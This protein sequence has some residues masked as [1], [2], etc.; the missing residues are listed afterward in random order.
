MTLPT[1]PQSIVDGAGA[2]RFGTYTGELSRIELANLTGRWAVPRAL[3]RLKRK[4]WQYT[5]VSTPEIAAFF[6]VVDLGYTANAFLTAVELGTGRVL[7]DESFLNVPGPHVEVSDTPGAGLSARFW[8]PGASFAASRAEGDE[9]YKVKVELSRVVR[10]LAGPVKWTGELLAAGGPPALTVIAP[11]AGD[12]K[13]NVTQ[14]WSALL[15]FGSLEVDGKRYRLDGGVGGMDY[16]QGF[17]ARHTA[18]RWAFSAGRLSDGTPIGFNLVEGFNESTSEGP[19]PPNENALWL[20]NELIPLPRAH[21]TFNKK[22][23]L[24]R[25]QMRTEDGSLEVNFK[26]LH[27]HREHRDL[28]VVKSWFV[29]PV[30][31]Y[32]GFVKLPD[33]RTLK[34]DALPGVAEDQDVLW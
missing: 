6:A 17:L 22:D 1:A 23:P 3:H 11:V 9:R 25:W 27:A 16:T 10:P 33:G 5:F 24:E 31:V 18:W 29:Q 4:K 26:P 12:G 20:G 7:V 14:K 8:L 15:A 34:F 28:R 19:N 2:P 13:V 30:G 32:E 21:F